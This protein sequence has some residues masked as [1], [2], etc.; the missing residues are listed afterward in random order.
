MPYGF[1]SDESPL[2]DLSASEI[3]RIGNSRPVGYINWT[4]VMDGVVHTRSTFR[5]IKDNSFIDV[6]YHNDNIIEGLFVHST[7]IEDKS[8]YIDTTDLKNKQARR[9]QETFQSSVSPK[10][11]S[12][13]TE[14]ERETLIENIVKIKKEDVENNFKLTEKLSVEV[15]E[16]AKRNLSQIL[17]FDSASGFLEAFAQDGLKLKTKLDVEDSPIHFLSNLCSIEILEKYVSDTSLPKKYQSIYMEKVIE[18]FFNRSK[19]E[20]DSARNSKALRYYGT[21]LKGEVTD[22]ESGQQG[23]QGHGSIVTRK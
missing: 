2:K 7:K 18:Y 8:D 20:A 16:I 9:K 12:L 5:P 23:Q 3:H 10:P 21:K 4:K 1:I 15:S 11:E 19:T 17:S 13:Q 14:R 22:K 6:K